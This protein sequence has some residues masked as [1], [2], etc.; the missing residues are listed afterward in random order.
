MAIYALFVVTIFWY[1]NGILKNDVVDV[2]Q[3][4]TAKKIAEIKPVKITLN[5]E[6]PQTTLSYNTT[7]NNSD[8]VLDLLNNIR[9]TTTFEYQKTSY[10]DR[11]EIDYINGIYP[12][13]SYKWKIFSGPQDITQVFQDTYLKDN[14]IYTI[15]LEKEN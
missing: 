14:G 4:Q 13:G 7:M 15:K 11:N 5:V 2:M 12:Q 3:Q 10:V 6:L 8:S 1:V 9:K